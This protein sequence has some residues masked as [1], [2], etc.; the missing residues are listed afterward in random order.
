MDMNQTLSEINDIN[1]L[2][3]ISYM[4]GSAKTNSYQS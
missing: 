2:K 4:D 1:F 3:K